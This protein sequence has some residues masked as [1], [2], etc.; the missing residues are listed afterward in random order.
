[1]QRTVSNIIKSPFRAVVLVTAIFT[2]H[3]LIEEEDEADIEPLARDQL[4]IIEN[5]NDD[6]QNK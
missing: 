4:E 2:L 3:N 5:D 1:M 6:S